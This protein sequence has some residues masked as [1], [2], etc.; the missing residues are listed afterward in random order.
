MRL[1]DEDQSL[2]AAARIIS[3]AFKTAHGETCDVYGL[4]AADLFEL[5][6]EIEMLLPFFGDDAATLEWLHNQ[7]MWLV[8]VCASKLRD[9]EPF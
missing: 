9:T 6:V 4:S 2:A 5:V 3:M 7:R 1:F 8:G